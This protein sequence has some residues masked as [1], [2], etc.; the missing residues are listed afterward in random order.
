M[1]VEWT[2]ARLHAQ[3]IVSPVQRDSI[4]AV[5]DDLL[6]W[7]SDWIS[8]HNAIPQ[9]L[10]HLLRATTRRPGR[11]RYLSK[12]AWHACSLIHFHLLSSLIGDRPVRRGMQLVPIAWQSYCVQHEFHLAS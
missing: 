6:V 8:A 3:S 5:F 1:Y 11:M 9:S 10:S 7:P 2:E 4:G 12:M